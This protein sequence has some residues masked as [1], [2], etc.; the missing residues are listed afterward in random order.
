[1]NPKPDFRRR[2][3]ERHATNFQDV[4]ETLAEEAVWRWGPLNRFYI[5][6]WL[7]EDQ[8]ANRG[9]GQWRGK[10]LYFFKRMAYRKISGVDISLEQV[11]LAKMKPGEVLNFIQAQQSVSDIGHLQ[12]EFPT[13]LQQAGKS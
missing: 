12:N 13:R 9:F 7:P 3:Y 8:C 4:T 2:I 11:R 1:M 5:R 6:N 10:L